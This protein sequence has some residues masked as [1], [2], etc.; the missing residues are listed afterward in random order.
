MEGEDIITR[1]QQQC[2]ILSTCTECFMN[3]KDVKLASFLTSNLQ[4]SMHLTQPMNCFPLT[5]TDFS[6]N[7]NTVT[8]DT[9]VFQIN[10][11]YLLE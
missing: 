1:E 8:C 7:S 2:K 9:G 6:C 5:I 4:W 10:R 3:A 11:V